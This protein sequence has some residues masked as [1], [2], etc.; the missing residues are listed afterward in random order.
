MIRER[1][2]LPLDDG[3]REKAKGLEIGG[4]GAGDAERVVGAPFAQIEA[5]GFFE[6]TGQFLKGG[7][8]S[9]FERSASVL[10][11]Y[12]LSDKE[13]EDFSFTDLQKGEGLDRL[14]VAEGVASGIVLQREVEAISHEIEIAL[15]GFIR[16]LELAAQF[17]AVDHLLSGEE[18][19]KT[20]HSF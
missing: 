13:G 12:L 9:F 20:L 18:I 14:G 4:R 3:T 17:L 2:F 10:G 19:V 16:D 7:T 8:E 5:D 6:G 11:E 1:N 15:N